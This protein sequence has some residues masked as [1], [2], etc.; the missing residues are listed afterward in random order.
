M[1]LLGKPSILFS[2]ERASRSGEGNSGAADGIISPRRN[3][4]Q[5]DVLL[6]SESTHFLFAFCLTFSPRLTWADA[7]KHK[8]KLR[9]QVVQHSDFFYSSKF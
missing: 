6:D 7:R 1:R 5:C 8:Q 2:S 9:Q 4:D 3:G